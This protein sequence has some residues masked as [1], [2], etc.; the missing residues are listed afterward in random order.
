MLLDLAK[1]HLLSMLG[2]GVLTNIFFGVQAACWVLAVADLL[3]VLAWIFQVHLDM[4]AL[5]GRGYDVAPLEADLKLILP[6]YAV[7]GMVSIF[8]NILD[9]LENFAREA[10]VRC[11][12]V[13]WGR[14]F[15]LV[16]FLV[17][18]FFHLLAVV[19]LFFWASSSEAKMPEWLSAPSVLVPPFVLLLIS[20]MVQSSVIY[21]GILRRIRYLEDHR[22]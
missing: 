12:G 16:N 22:A 4:P 2:R 5:T 8:W 17:M 10:R 9:Q 1:F 20:I 11:P 19:F 7:W 15:A 13:A 14:S 18:I 21:R 6:V 3:A